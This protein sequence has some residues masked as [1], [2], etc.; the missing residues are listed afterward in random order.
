M[1]SPQFRKLSAGLRQVAANIPLSWGKVQNDRY[2]NDL[3]DVCNIF[4][5]TSLPE[6]EGYITQFDNAHQLYYKRR[7]YSVRLAD[8]DEYLFYR[9]HN[10][11]HNPNRFDKRWDIRING[12]QYFDIKSTRIPVDSNFNFPDALQETQ[13]LIE[14]YY[15]NQSKGVRYS[16]NNRLF[17]VHHSI[18]SPGR[19][20]VLRCAWGT[21][22]AVFTRFIQNINHIHFHSYKGCT[23]GIIFLVETEHN[24]MKYYIDGLDTELQT[25]H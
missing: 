1:T 17:L 2:D 8:C 18:C 20:V 10:V 6:L 13:R 4:E 22:N 5:V 3:K 14:W 9:H 23:A 25:I 15:D 11:E 16:M 24:V 21:K 7:W 12:M 19:E